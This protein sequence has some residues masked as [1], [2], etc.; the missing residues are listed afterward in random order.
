MIRSYKDLEVWKKGMD[1]VDAIYGATD[2]FPQYEIYSLTS[3]MRRAAVSIP[4]NIAEGHIPFYT[5]SFKR[6]CK[7]SLGSCAEL[8]TQLII[9]KKRNY[10]GEEDFSRISLMLEVEIKMLISLIRK[11][12]D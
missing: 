8:D 6:Y 4:S 7:T 11:L 10:I 2:K 12:K 3:Q 9:S 1:I 5:T